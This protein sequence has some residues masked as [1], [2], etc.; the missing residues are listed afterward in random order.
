MLQYTLAGVIFPVARLLLMYYTRRLTID[1][2]TGRLRPNAY[3][4]VHCPSALLRLVHG[5]IPAI[6]WPIE[7]TLVHQ[8][9]LLRDGDIMASPGDGS[10]PSA[11]HSRESL[12]RRSSL[13][14][15]NRQKLFVGQNYLPARIIIFTI[16]GA[17]VVLLTFGIAYP[18]LALA[19]AV[20]VSSLTAVWQIILQTHINDC[21]A[22]PNNTDHIH[23]FRRKL[24]RDCRRLW[25]V[26]TR[27]IGLMLVCCSGFYALYF[28]DVTP[29]SL[30]LCLVSV[31]IPL[32]AYIVKLMMKYGVSGA[33]RTLTR[34]VVRESMERG[35]GGVSM[36]WLRVSNSLRGRGSSASSDEAI[37]GQGLPP[38]IE[39]PLQAQ[40]SPGA[41]GGRKIPPAGLP[42]EH[43]PDELLRAMSL[44]AQEPPRQS[45][46]I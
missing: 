36:V 10:S 14:S 26:F 30:T 25:K 19:I 3:E 5:N 12:I 4:L 46:I 1:P 29:G 22:I 20:S 13:E 43:D 2:A 7:Y 40:Y 17:Y 38:P 28:M 9:R 11:V 44:G 37:P 31:L 32:A 18:P 27:S 35:T 16:I 24:E 39:N 8:Q 33:Y 41:G 21:F 23:L 34:T 6:L 45:G 42:S 15:S